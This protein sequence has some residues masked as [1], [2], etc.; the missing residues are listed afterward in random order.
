MVVCC[1]NG[2]M[3]YIERE[4]LRKREYYLSHRLECNKRTAERLKMKYE[5]DKEYRLT[6][7]KNGKAYR[8]KHPE[9]NR[10][11]CARYHKKN[12]QTLQIRAKQYY[13]LNK[14]R[15]MAYV[16]FHKLGLHKADTPSELFDCM[17]IYLTL[18]SR[19]SLLRG[20]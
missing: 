16:M 11:K 1:N 17:V 5:T 7:S 8:I 4:K 12:K 6:V 2:Y 15:I 20:S 3:D 9:K 14:Y 10:E 19:I 13:S 18:R